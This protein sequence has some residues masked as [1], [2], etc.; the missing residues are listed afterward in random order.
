MMPRKKA[1]TSKA[2]LKIDRQTFDFSKMFKN[3]TL[4]ETQV[5][6]ELCYCELLVSSTKQFS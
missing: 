1:L 3:K 6:L 2:G 5:S 4:I